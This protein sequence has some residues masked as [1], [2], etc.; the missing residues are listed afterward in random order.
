MRKT[1][2]VSADLELAFHLADLAD[3]T[4]L[5]WWSPNG[6][7]SAPKT[8]GSPVTE[9]DVA[10]EKAL[11]N[12][13]AKAVP[14]DGFLGEEVGGNRGT[15][16]RRWIVDGIDGTRSFVVGR[17]EWGTLIALEWDS[18]IVLGVSSSPVQER[19]WWAARGAGAFSGH[20]KDRFGTRSE[21]RS[22]H[23]AAQ[24]RRSVSRSAGDRERVGGRLSSGPLL[25]P[26]ESDS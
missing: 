21:S 17:P 24:L 9:A 18:E 11:L 5:R 3:A 25:E 20:S 26:P 15:T 14:G 12:A 22:F 13:V 16:G 19:R 7:A 1:V 4:T 10:V 8:D 6:V 23:H 2:A